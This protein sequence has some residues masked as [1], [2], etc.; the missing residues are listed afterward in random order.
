MRVCQCAVC[1]RLKPKSEHKSHF[2]QYC[3]LYLT[4]TGKRSISPTRMR[5]I[6]ICLAAMVG[7]GSPNNR[8]EGVTES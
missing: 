3:A 7:L 1:Y 2:V 5:T 6:F 4:V 8:V